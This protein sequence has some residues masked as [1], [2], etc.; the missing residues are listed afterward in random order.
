MTGTFPRGSEWRRWDLHV[1]TPHSVLN[2]RFGP[3]FDAYARL[4][5]E[6]AATKDIASIGIT[7]Y[8]SV[9]GYRQITRLLAD[10]AWL[11]TLPDHV[12]EHATSLL[13]L[14]NVELRGFV[15]GGDERRDSRVNYH[16]LFSN[17]LSADEIE[18]DFLSRLEFTAIGAPGRQDE[19][20]PLTQRDLVALGTRLKEQHAR[21]PQPP[22]EVGMLNAVI[23][24]DEVTDVLVRQPSRFDGKYFL[25]APIDEDLA[26]LRWDG[27]GHLTRKVF[28]QKSDMIFSG[29]PG[30]RE[31]ALGN[32]HDSIEEY[33]AEFV[34]IKPCIHG[35][36]AHDFESLFEP[37]ERR[38]NWIKADP[39]WRGLAMLLNESADR[40]HIGP[41]P[42]QLE[43]V[44]R[45]LAKTL[46]SVAVSRSH[47]AT[48]TEQWFEN[49]VPLNAGL[50]A[51]I[52]NRGNGKGALAE[53]IGLL[54]DTHRTDSFSFLSG[55]KFRHPRIGK[56]EQFEAAVAWGDGTAQGPRRLSE[57]PAATTVERVR[58]IGQGYLEEICNEMDRGESSRFYREL[59]D[60]IFSHVSEAD[61][62]GHPTLASLLAALGEGIN[63]AIDA[64]RDEIRNLNRRIVEITQQLRPEFRATV[65]ARLGE[66]NRQ[67]AAHDAARPIEVPAPIE[68]TD[69]GA[70]LQADIERLRNEVQRLDVRIA[71]A[72][73]EDAQLAARAAAATRLLD[74]VRAIEA[75]LRGLADEG[76][77]DA[78]LVGIDL[79]TVVR[80]QVDT[81][82]IDEVVRAAAARRLAIREDLDPSQPGVAQA[83]AQVLDQIGAAQERLT[84]PQRRY[85]EYRTALA[86]WE[87]DR[88]TLIGQPDVPASIS[89]LRAQIEA[90]ER[91]PGSLAS[92]VDRRRTKALEIY[93]AKERLKQQYEALHRPV[94][95][96]LESSGVA[97][98]EALKLKFSAQILEDGFADTFLAMIHQRRLGAFAGIEEGRAKLDAMLSDVDWSSA[99]QAANFP[100]AVVRELTGDNDSPR[101]IEGQL[102]QGFGSQELLDFLF[103]LEYVA[104]TYKLTWDDRIV[105]ELSPGERGNLL[106]IFYL[107]VDR[108]DIPLVI[109]QPEENL[110]NQTVYKTLVPCMRDARTRRQVVVV[111]HNPNLAVVCDADQVIYAEIQKDGTN[112]VVYETGSIEDPLINRRL[113]DVLEGTKPAFD[114]RAAKYLTAMRT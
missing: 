38:Y 94:S 66:L 17:E 2:N 42:P 62:Q 55:D 16:V 86:R 92:L 82:Q 10:E 61:R 8:F 41:R 68:A 43:Q 69:V 58:Y 103:G 14:A 74:R 106:L 4:L 87:L 20:W 36:D 88:A 73:Q 112:R 1:H 85:E 13:I 96:F 114:Q 35:S 108:S 107:L 83:R 47:D 30:T 9:E 77:E 31:F 99:E 15:I 97:A 24:H 59:Q 71:E 40:V 90:L 98:R 111:T 65:E 19:K 102:R 54:G 11:N 44:Q 95:E 70:A 28:I 34:S 84:L 37:D 80:I 101:R 91:L 72:R 32:R 50:C 105:S 60:V 57:N 64:L 48:T 27:Q 93:A 89:G 75:Y 22:L 6:A 63:Q 79:S 46:T 39:T 25:V 3:D 45:R 52:G 109:D 56:A 23:D 5:L 100:D 18:S 26:D 81:A 113:V 33:L 78:R 110:D 29:N 7:D 21:F 12:R 49:E 104:P 67:L 53:I 51:I 76:A